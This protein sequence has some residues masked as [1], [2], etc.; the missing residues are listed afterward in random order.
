MINFIKNNIYRK[1][2]SSVPDIY[3]RPLLPLEIKPS[4]QL[5]KFSQIDSRHDVQQSCSIYNTNL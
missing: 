2:A 3:P 4:S 5:K 1:V